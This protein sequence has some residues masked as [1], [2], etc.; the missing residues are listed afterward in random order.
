MRFWS[1]IAG[2]VVGAIVDGGTGACFGFFIGL[3]A[4]ILTRQQNMIRTLNKEMRSIRANF[5][6]N[7]GEMAE[8]ATPTSQDS[9]V[10]VPENEETT[11][12]SAPETKPA[13]VKSSPTI[14]SPIP[15]VT[16]VKPSL[17]DKVL[18][19]AK[20]FLMTGN[21]VAK[22]GIIILF[23]GVGFLL[24]YAADQNVWS[25]EYRLIGVI[26]VGIV[27]FVFGWR[28][29]RK[30]VTYALILQGGAMG[31]L[32]LTVF[33][34]AK[35]YG[36]LPL[37]LTFFIM[38]A[39]VVLSCWFAVMQNAC[40]LAVIATIGGFLAPILTSDDSGNHLALF[41]YYALLNTGILGIA[42]YKAWRILN[43]FGFL[44]TFVIAS[45][46]GYTGYQPE[47]FATTEPF[48]ILFFLFY[49]AMTILFAY[50]QPPELKGLVDGSL[51]FGVPLV[52]FTLQSVLVSD[53]EYGQAISAL[54]IAALYLTLAK[55][56]W[57]KRVAG[58][59]M[60][61]E[62]YLALGIIFASLTI[63]F[64]L[65]N[66]WI[67]IFWVIEGAGITWL[68][69][70]QQRLAARWFGLLLQA[71]GAI[72]LVI[73]PEYSDTGALPIFNS[74]YIGT[75]LISI[76]GLFTAYQFYRNR[77][78][79]L[80]WE[81]IFDLILLVWGLE[82]WI[83]AGYREIDDYVAAE[84]ILNTG[85]LF[86]GIS[87]LAASLLGRYLRWHLL[88]N[89][90]FLLLPTMLVYACIMFYQEPATNPLAYLGYIAWPFAFAAQYFLLY[91][92]EKTWGRKILER[93]HAVT[94]WLY[95]FMVT[96]ILAQA[97]STHV[98]G[99]ANW[100][101]LF[102]GLFPA[103]AV[104]KLLYVRR[105]ITWPIQYFKSA[106]LSQGLLPVIAYL[107]TWII[108]AC[109]YEANPAPLPYLP[110]L[111][112]Q[113]LVQ[114]IAMYF[115]LD[116]TKQLD[117]HT[118]PPME[119]A[120]PEVLKVVL[121]GIAFIWLNALVAQVVHFYWGVGYTLKALTDS[122]VFQTGITIVWTITAFGIMAFSSRI[123]QKQFWFVGTGLLALVVLKLF[124][125][126]LAELGTIPTIISFISV[127]LLML[128]AGYATPMPRK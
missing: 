118:I 63:P 69:F 56:L 47:H 106:Y 24:K 57:S 88:R 8:A 111:N 68:G 78:Q 33:S 1:S 117:D 93:W 91:Q 7:R 123:G 50:R 45:L 116:W 76:A 105:Y 23:L 32:Y 14:G 29:R 55:V 11:T 79:L 124:A 110:I 101:H 64:A 17:A 81:K 28:L 9:K 87:I 16:S 35:L 126:D 25:I 41:S 52:G 108:V 44:F 3:L 85:L 114:L 2:V 21:A 89:I 74:G 72:A 20:H 128:L 104:F 115:I 103:L 30:N 27:M 12:E 96:W 40:S 51:V 121:A 95:V 107:A 62:A 77:A 38:F 120:R 100:N 99:L 102:W 66:T 80:D 39:L 94:M 75:L 83:V 112:P 82:W 60:L 13:M 92:S 18:A 122:S 42:W 113:D 58:M 86:V 59:R 49:V 34:A 84:Y 98:P 109:F 97:L 5:I 6:E 4:G 54:T 119:E 48:L 46:W 43:W 10:Q 61:V 71:G 36:V 67:T 31:L 26:M 90:A 73:S 65:D 37:S 15:S 19:Y 127:G 125:I 70:R 22:V 53:F